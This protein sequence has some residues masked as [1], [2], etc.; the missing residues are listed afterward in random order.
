MSIMPNIVLERSFGSLDVFGELDYTVLLDDPATHDLA[1]EI[2]L[3]YN[4]PVSEAGTVTLILNNQNTIVVKPEL[5]EGATNLGTLEPAVQ[6]THALATGD[7]SAKVGLPFDYLTG[8]KDETALGTYLTLGWAAASGLGLEVTGNLGLK[9]DAEFAGWGFLGSY[10]KGRF[11]GEVEI[12]TGKEFE[13][14]EIL[15]EIDVTLGAAVLILRG[16]LNKADSDSD[17][18]FTPFIGV[19]YHF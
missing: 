19:G 10:E 7:F 8:V 14:W 1:D 13:D 18:S 3:G 6:Y 2:E 17:W 12:N 5:P 4:L 9:P 15:P 11:Y 16:D